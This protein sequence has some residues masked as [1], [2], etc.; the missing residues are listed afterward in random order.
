[1]RNTTTPQ[2]LANSTTEDDS[3][4]NRK[5]FGVSNQINLFDAMVDYSLKSDN[6]IIK[7]SFQIENLKK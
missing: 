7:K 2:T 4:V 1:M 6:G 3:I 5:F